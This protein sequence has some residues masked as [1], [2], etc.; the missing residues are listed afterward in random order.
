MRTIRALLAGLFLAASCAVA[1][2]QGLLGI[3]KTVAAIASTPTVNW[4]NYAYNQSAATSASVAEGS[5]TIHSGDFLLAFV[6]WV[7]GTTDPGSITKPSGWTQVTNT[8][9]AAGGNRCGIFYRFSTGDTGPYSFTVT[10]SN[11]YTWVLGDYSSVNV[12]APLDPVTPSDTQY[13][14][15]YSASIVAPSVSPVAA[16]NL[17]LAVWVF[18]A[19]GT[20]TCGAGCTVTIDTPYTPTNSGAPTVYLGHLA[21]VAAGATATQTLTYQYSVNIWEAL[22]LTLK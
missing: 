16:T 5:N 11:P 3:D 13:N 19:G 14:S 20:L 7:N 15:T 10:N 4:T 22:Q 18:N 9:Y 6:C 1:S 12:G 21:L 8:Y 2:A 17:D